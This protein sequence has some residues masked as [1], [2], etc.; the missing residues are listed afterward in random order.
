MPPST[1]V[2]LAEPQLS[3]FLN[4]VLESYRLQGL[5]PRLSVTSVEAKLCKVGVRLGGISKNT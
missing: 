2:L 3:M 4:D 1:L 5:V